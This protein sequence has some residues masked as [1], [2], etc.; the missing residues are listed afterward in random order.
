MALDLDD[1]A[2]RYNIA[3]DGSRE[4]DPAPVKGS[5]DDVLK[6]EDDAYN[7][8][9][10]NNPKLASNLDSNTLF[11]T[12]PTSD[13]GQ[14]ADAILDPD[15]SVTDPYSQQTSSSSSSTLPTVQNPDKYVYDERSAYSRAD[16]TKNLFGANLD[17]VSK[18]EQVTFESKADRSMRNS[19]AYIHPWTRGGTSTNAQ[20]I[21]QTQNTPTADS[22]RT[23]IPSLWDDMSKFNSES[24]FLDYSLLGD[25]FDL[26][27]DVVPK[28]KP[29]ESLW[30]G[31]TP[32]F[33]YTSSFNDEKGN[34]YGNDLYNNFFKDGD[35]VK[36]TTSEAQAK[37]GNLKA[38]TPTNNVGQNIGQVLVE[39]GKLATDILLRNRPDQGTLAKEGIDRIANF[40]NV[41][42]GP[43]FAGN[44]TGF[45]LG[46]ARSALSAFTAATTKPANSTRAVYRGTN[47]PIN[48]QS[49]NPKSGGGF[50][51]PG[52]GTPA[53][54]PPEAWQFLFN[55][56]Q[57]QLTV[58]PNFKETETWGV[59][60]EPNA[61]K[62]LHWTSYKNPQLKFSK[63]LLNGYVFG[64]KVEELEQGLIELFMKN[65]TNDAKHGPRVLEFVWG[66]KTFGPCVIKDVRVN[67]KMWDE[68][69]LVNAEV[70]FTLERVPEWTINDGQ[71]S[72]YDPS[73]QN[74]IIKPAPSKS[75]PQSPAP[76][77][78]DK[79]QPPEPKPQTEVGWDKAKCD[80]VK[81][82]LG[83]RDVVI[84]RVIDIRAIMKN[85]GKEVRF[86]TSFGPTQQNEQVGRITSYYSS[87]LDVVQ[88]T[89]TGLTYD[90]AKCGR[91][92][93]GQGRTKLLLDLEAEQQASGEAQYNAAKQTLV[94]NFTS[95]IMNCA[96]D[97]G[98]ALEARYNTQ[99]N[100][101]K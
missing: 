76:D 49:K 29:E 21:G 80:K 41:P 26:G 40:F 43:T 1:I 10:L 50:A 11:K 38:D 94:N 98:K 68:G 18:L 52:F 62:P 32:T 7:A 81:Q 92:A 58:G 65:P 78:S 8:W 42:S 66:K 17:V 33:D 39:G 85:K 30:S 70:D 60:D 74:P 93:I 59:G 36:T 24:P 3:D 57:I 23:I 22:I 9:S 73:A 53:I 83:N 69:L 25:D 44:P 16:F 35:E 51:N 34:V 2:N 75:K 48:L 15:K 28:W 72:T 46:Q 12:G 14:R 87:W 31:E 4:G 64:R 19:I 96:N 56:S 63:V 45:L 88:S 54:S 77:S 86:F 67:Q 91:E 20:E 5:L 47:I 101:S 100:K 6:A 37:Q 27:V 90:H 99:C 71:V 13:T 55:P 97:V 89:D 82:A 79:T 61:G 84:N 95:K